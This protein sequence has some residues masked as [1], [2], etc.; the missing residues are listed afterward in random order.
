MKQVKD[1]FRVDLEGLSPGH[2]Y[3]PLDLGHGSVILPPPSRV[4]VQMS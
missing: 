3:A 2:G 1:L 4:I